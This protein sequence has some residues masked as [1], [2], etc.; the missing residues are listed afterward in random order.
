MADSPSSRAGTRNPDKTVL[1]LFLYIV[2]PIIL[3]TLVACEPRE[4]A[5]WSPD[6]AHAALLAEYRLF[7]AEDDGTLADP[8]PE[9]DGGSGRFLY[10]AVSWLSDSSGLVA[11]RLRISQDWPSV[12]GLLA[13]P[14]AKRVENLAE[15][16][17]ELLRTAIALHGDTDQAEN[18]LEKFIPAEGVTSLNALR[19][20][21]DTNPDSVREAIKSAP[22]VFASLDSDE[23]EDGGYLIHE[24]VL[25]NH[26]T[27]EERILFGGLRGIHSPRVSP[28]HSLVAVAM[29]TDEPNRYDLLIQPIDGAPAIV[30]AEGTSEA[31]DWTPDGASLV[32]MSSLGVGG[33]PL[34]K[35]E[36]RLVIDESGTVVSGP[37]AES[38]AVELAYALVP[39]APRLT[40]LPRG[41]ILFAS[42]PGSLPSPAGEPEHN[43]RLYLLPAQGGEAK[44]VP[45]TEGTLPMDLGYFS[46]SPDGRRV[47][48]VESG[49]NAVAVIDLMTGKS[50]LV[51]SPHSGWKSRLL[52]SWKS[53]DEFSYAAVDPESRRV[54]WMIWRSGESTEFSEN[55]PDS[56]TKGWM[57]F[58]EVTP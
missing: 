13:E 8:L 21:M 18:L 45:T 7:F 29:E 11:H 6:G 52:P 37:V 23:K 48:V 56:I 34:M 47:V 28:D 25:I 58:K 14:D 38:L 53:S 41:E 10:D 22:G 36:R 9:N 46:P 43:P 1:K 5:E 17:P 55:W 12:R 4:R 32:Y 50:D 24:L 3:L 26:E 19:L 51:S 57:E 31:F 49:T 42:Q 54:R 30:I 33:G 20:A 15:R 16:V 2:A 27:R 40:V 35:I 39:F 44:A